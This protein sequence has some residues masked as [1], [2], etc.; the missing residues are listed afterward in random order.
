MRRRSLRTSQAFLLWASIL[1]AFALLPPTGFH[2]FWGAAFAVPALLLERMGR[3]D[4]APSLEIRAL[5]VVQ[6]VIAG[7]A[8]LL[9]TIG[10]AH[11]AWIPSGLALG[12]CAFFAARRRG[13]DS[14]IALGL[15]AAVLLVRSFATQW[16]TDAPTMEWMLLPWFL[17]AVLTLRIAQLERFTDGLELGTSGPRSP[18]P[19]GNSL[20]IA[21]AGLAIALLAGLV[22]L[23]IDQMVRLRA[24]EAERQQKEA[25]KKRDSSGV[26]FRLSDR[27]ELSGREPGSE[28]VLRDAELLRVRHPDG[29]SLAESLYLRITAFAEPGLESWGTDL[30]T[31]RRL[32]PDERIPAGPRARGV[33]LQE[34]RIERLAGHRG[35]MYVPPGILS[36]EADAELFVDRQALHVRQQFPGPPKPLEY[37]VTFQDFA[38]RR[39]AV[40]ER[41]RYLRVP[42]EL[43]A[44]DF[45]ELAAELRRRVAD[46]SPFELA[47]AAAELLQL[48][49]RYERR[50][51]TGPYRSSLRNFLFGDNIGY[52]MHFASAAAILLRLS[53][54]PC[55]IAVGLYGGDADDVDSSVR[56]FGSQ[57]AH[58]WV[59][60]P[61]AD[62]GWVVFDPTPPEQRA[63][64]S[65][66]G[67]ADAFGGEDEDP[68]FAPA[69]GG[70]PALGAAA[71]RRQRARPAGPPLAE[72]PPRGVTPRHDADPANGPSAAWRAPPSA[73][74][75]RPADRA[76]SDLGELPPQSRDQW[77]PGEQRCGPR[78]RCLPGAALRRS[79]V[80]RSPRGLSPR[81]DRG[82]RAPADRG[83][84]QLSR[85]GRAVRA[86]T[87]GTERLRESPIEPPCSASWTCRSSCGRRLRPRTAAS[88]LQVTPNCRRR[89][90]TSIAASRRPS[91]W[92]RS[93]RFWLRHVPRPTS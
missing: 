56:I 70:S 19:L 5:I 8:V 31:L 54:V 68:D 10:L 39:G 37:G 85:I 16:L 91:S 34:L 23:R 72:A 90:S 86:S 15:C 64:G 11:D 84:T 89:S 43:Q 45:L 48:R 69:L 33:P 57:H 42:G 92:S 79:P 55:R 81:S 4:D 50:E 77:F 14:S 59:E 13:R 76:A 71:D 30:G 75:L 35:L 44:E 41:P 61:V 52:C 66:P 32:G 58:A 26:D 40:Q 62:M 49:C 63:T 67:L 17:L 47:G 73:R 36:I 3:G 1:S 12:A 21:A 80:E 88:C 38:G 29:R 2:W 74:E 27:F 51:P 25:R 93:A 83:V 7:V 78:L 87:P 24:H 82:R 46:A 65:L 28:L 22:I 9:L 20:R 18:V 53:G 60:L 6:L